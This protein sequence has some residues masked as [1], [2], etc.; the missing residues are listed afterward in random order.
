M[1][2]HNR[3]TKIKRHKAAVGAAKGKLFTKIIKELTVSSKLGGGDPAGNARLRTALAAARDANM[4]ADTITRAIKK[5]TGELEGVSYE[6]VLYEGY[7]PGGVA[8][9]V[10]CLTDNINRTAGDVRSTFGKFEG[11]LGTPGSV[12]FVF[13]HK[14][15]I[16]VKP[17]PTEDLV[18]EKAI[19]AG[20]EDVINHG[21]DGFEVRTEPNDMHKVAEALEKGGL[22][23]GEQKWVWIPS[24]SVKVEGDKAKL[25]L[26]LMENLEDNDDVQNVFANFEMD[27][28]LLEQLSG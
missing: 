11:N 16:A 2:G 22:K 8:M 9:L 10:E 12:K 18:M 5:G 24:T 26:K 4:P 15:T 6:E 27:E 7:G 1:S 20:A 3:W 28:T 23:L 17:G 13:T 21:A 25:L 14:G 19:D